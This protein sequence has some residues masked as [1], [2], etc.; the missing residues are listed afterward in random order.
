MNNSPELS[1]VMSVYNGQDHL[2]EAIESIL[3]QTYT[4]FE[5]III[6]DGSTDATKN[7]IEN[8]AVKDKRIIPVHQQNIGLTRSLNK[9]IEEAKAKY[10]ARMDADDV[11]Q[12][13]RLETQMEFLK[14]SQEIVLCG[15]WFLED[16]DG[17][18][19]KIRKYPVDDYALRKKIKYVNNFCHPSVVFLKDAFIKAGNYDERCSTGQDFELWMR[20]CN[21]G[22]IANIPKILVRRRIGTG[23]TISWQRRNEKSKLWEIIYKKHFKHW[24]QVNIILFIRFYIPLLFY[25][26]IPIPLIKIIRF[27]RYR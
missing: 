4:D 17:K 5:F 9:G 12:Q 27:F 8:Y 26:Y 15:T 20:L 19:V 24:N 13:N 6:N 21:Y 7:I 16:N 2:A 3:N 14:S 22:K 10:I 11:S 18:G 25:Q 1:V 23:N